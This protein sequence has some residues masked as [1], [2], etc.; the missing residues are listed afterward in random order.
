MH[1][2]W[3]PIATLAAAVSPTLPPDCLIPPVRAPIV[4]FF[5]APS[6]PWCPGQRGI[7]YGIGTSVSVR[8]AAAGLVTFTGVVVGVRYAVVT[9][10]DGFVATY[11][12][13]D[14]TSLRTGEYVSAGQLVGHASS[15]L[16]F[17]LRRDGT[18]VD[19]V[20]RLGVASTRPR[21]VPSDG[22]RRRPARDGP[23]T[24]RTHT[25]FGATIRTGT[26]TEFRSEIRA[27]R[28]SLA[29]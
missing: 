2:F 21:L 8:A 13:L 27:A 9:Q 12:M 17:G 7:E 1:V 29:R 24:C 25:A 10:F 14:D 15:R 19:P 4:V 22:S 6:C 26:S 5:R 18:Y 20:P 28:A 16:Y 3:I 23:P 11:G